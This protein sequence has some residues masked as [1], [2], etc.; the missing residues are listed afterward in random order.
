MDD[1]GCFVLGRPYGRRGVLSLFEGGSGGV[2][3]VFS[4]KD[5]TNP[6]LHGTTLLLWLSTW[7]WS[8]QSG[9]DH[10]LAAISLTI[11]QIRSLSAVNIKHEVLY[12]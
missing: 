3:K 9:T 5:P 4:R 6:L 2:P 1:T 8:S 10:V 7:A 12:C 11:N